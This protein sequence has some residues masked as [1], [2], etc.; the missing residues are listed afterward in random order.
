M[1]DNTT[2]GGVDLLTLESVLYYCHNWF[3][4]PERIVQGDFTISSGELS[5]ISEQLKDGQYYR[6]V[7]SDFNDGLHQ[8]G[9]ADD[10]L[11][12]ET[13]YGA[14][15]PLS[16][17][18]ALI[19]LAGEIKDWRDKYEAAAASPYTSESFAG[20]SYTKASGVTV[21]DGAGGWQAAFRSQLSRWR[22]LR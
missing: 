7:G 18:P 3:F 10:L 17:P 11:T 21:E 14:V 6:I 20:A 2:P 4:K 13:F 15:L 5:G 16:V 8:W 22:K 1:P 12:D 19:A 9:R